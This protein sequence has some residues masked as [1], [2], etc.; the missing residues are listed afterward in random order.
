V[1]D[2][3]LQGKTARVRGVY[4]DMEAR[5]YVAVTVDDDP[6]SDLHEWHGRSLFF[7]CDEVEP[8]EAPS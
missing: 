4:R 6:A 7:G 3:F 5:V 8:L 1:W 2:A